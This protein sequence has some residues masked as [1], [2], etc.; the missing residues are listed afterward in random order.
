MIFG[1][2]GESEEEM[3]ESAKQISLLPLNNIKFHQ[4]QII[5]DTAIEDEYRRCPDDFTIF[6]LEDYIEFIIKYLENLNPSF[7]V[8][9]IAG[10][11]PPR[12]NAGVKW[13]LRYDQI[14]AGLEKRMEER[15]TWQGRLYMKEIIRNG[16]TKYNT[17]K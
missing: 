17:G 8:E 6:A 16:E 1:L 2:P 9:R 15:N 5:K 11:T 10:E 13:G 14:L 4:L 12:Y 7:V 3:L